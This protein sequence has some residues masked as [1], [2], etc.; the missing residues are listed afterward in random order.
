MKELDKLELMRVVLPAMD[1]ELPFQVAGFFLFFSI[2]GFQSHVV[3][4]VVVVV[5]DSSHIHE[6]CPGLQAHQDISEG[7]C[8]FDS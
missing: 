1:K 2:K 3:V 8:Q 5:K 6:V 7:S 4:V